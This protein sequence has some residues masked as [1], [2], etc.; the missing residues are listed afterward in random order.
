M[1]Y[2]Y[3][4]VNAALHGDACPASLT[5]TKPSVVISNEPG[6]KTLSLKTN[7][8]LS[9][10]ILDQSPMQSGFSLYFSNGTHVLVRATP[11]S[12]VTYAPS[13]NA[14]FLFKD[15]TV[16]HKYGTV[17]FNDATATCVLSLLL[18][19]RQ[20]S[21]PTGNQQK[22]VSAITAL[23]FLANL[24]ADA[25]GRALAIVPLVSALPSGWPQSTRSYLLRVSTSISF[26]LYLSAQTHPAIQRMDPPRGGNAVRKV[27]HAITPT[28]TRMDPPRGGNAVRKVAHAITPTSTVRGPVSR[29]PA[30]GFV[31]ARAVQSDDEALEH[32]ETADSDDSSSSIGTAVTCDLLEETETLPHPSAATGT[33]IPPTTQEEPDALPVRAI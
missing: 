31:N 15:V 26:S 2:T 13:P 5:Q 16:T 24:W 27:A 29:S 33:A 23:T 10:T 28:S 30:A 21:R 12:T 7:F 32:E 25:T 6:V 1:N 19:P 18:P 3:W 11:H 22:A 14:L 17:T 9:M 8:Q 4:I 20:T